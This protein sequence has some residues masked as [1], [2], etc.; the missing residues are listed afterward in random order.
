M[1]QM[2][3]VGQGQGWF[4]WDGGRHSNRF[5]K[6][7]YAYICARIIETNYLQTGR[8]FFLYSILTNYFFGNLGE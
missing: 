1:Q 2:K 4:R 8:S 3:G 7:V 5:I 6:Y